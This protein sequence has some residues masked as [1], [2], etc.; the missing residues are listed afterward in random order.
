M[1]VTSMHNL[2]LQVYTD[3]QWRNA[4][5]VCFEQSE[6]G[7]E[8]TCDPDQLTLDLIRKFLAMFGAG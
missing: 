6:E 7:L 1:P 8:G 5:E 3:G 4:M 2:T